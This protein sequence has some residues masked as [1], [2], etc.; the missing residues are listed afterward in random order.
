[1]TPYSEELRR[2]DGQAPSGTATMLRL[3]LV[4]K[5]PRG[6]AEVLERVRDVLGRVVGA[7]ASGSEL[8]DARKWRETLP[9]WFVEACRPEMSQAEAL[10]WLEKWRALSPPQQAA[11]EERQAWSLEDWLHWFAKGPDERQWRWLSGQVAAPDRL[12]VTLE[13]AGLP[14][15][16]G[17]LTWLLRAAG[18][19]AIIE[20]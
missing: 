2:L 18:A 9:S 19:T 6:A 4:A 12:K 16:Y 13:V 5:C 7:L 15:A 11:E 10:D 8:P 3:V 17:A 1:M 20:A 14:T